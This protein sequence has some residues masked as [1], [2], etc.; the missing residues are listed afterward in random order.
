[1]RASRLLQILL[2]LQSRGR[3]T[4]AAL[5][6]ALAV[7]PRTIPRDV[8]ALSAAGLRRAPGAAHVDS[9]PDRGRAM[10]A[11]WGCSTLGRAP[12]P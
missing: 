4:A 12:L 9:I 7:T 2:V 3:L 10:M 6:P 5:A 8:D 11:D 1:M